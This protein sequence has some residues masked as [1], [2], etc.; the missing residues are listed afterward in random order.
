MPPVNGIHYTSVTNR[1]M[2]Y[3]E[4]VESRDTRKNNKTRMPYGYFHKRLIDKKYGNFLE[5][6]D[7]L[8]DNISFAD[9]VKSDSEASAKL[10]DKH[11]LRFTPNEGDDGV[12]AVAI[13]QG[14]FI[15]F[16]Q[17][18][19]E[20]P[21][22]VA[23][24][25]FIENTITDLTEVTSKLNDA[26]VLHL[27]FAPSNILVR[28]NDNSIRLLCHG[29]FYQK[30][31]MQEELYDGCED[32]VAPEVMAGGDVTE[33][34]DVYGIGTFINW[35]YSSSGIPIEL[36]GIIAKAT[37]ADPS[38]R[39][40]SVAEMAK[41]IG[42]RRQIRRTGWIAVS[43]AAVAL[44]IVALFFD[45]MPN[46]SPVEFVSPVEE[47]ISDDLLDDGFDPTTE[48]G[49]SADSAAIA[50]AV[51]KA[52][53]QRD[54]VNASMKQM[55]EYEA[56]AEQIFRRQYTKVAD[57]ILSQIY[58]PDGSNLS[59][60]AY[61]AKNQRLLDE[62]VRKQQELASQTHLSDA[63]TQTIASEIIERL[64]EQK[65][66]QSQQRLGAQTQSSSGE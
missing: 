31:Q 12:Y 37:A 5:F 24:D 22:I 46:T 21:S 11:Q 18:V 35:L 48:L 66:A 38:D 32:F 45:M 7:E 58:S 60:R 1:D 36:K 8:A 29:S 17:L 41:A 4:L 27:C 47:M 51:S 28:R 59:E 23:Q 25:G 10:S 57:R 64:T 2:N 20:N 40:D 26:G 6:N 14:N 9:S 63:K 54:S 39:Y 15:T 65:K 56:K 53:I 3:E 49:V 50:A 62:L 34:S 19:N 42:L 43:A 61:M 55:R 13:E 52:N 33:R 30:L 44:I 16:E